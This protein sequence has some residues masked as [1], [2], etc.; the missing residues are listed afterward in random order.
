V[1]LTSGVF[2]LLS[3]GLKSLAVGAILGTGCGG[4]WA[5]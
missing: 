5:Y 2:G 3:G 4:M 1:L